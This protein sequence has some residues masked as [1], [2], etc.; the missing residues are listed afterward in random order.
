[1]LAAKSVMTRRQWTSLLEALVRIA[2]VGHVAWV[3]EVHRQVWE[4]V[5]RAL[6]GE[7]LP[8]DLRATIYPSNS[9]T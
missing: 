9:A 7:D 2:A 8:G 1:M 5:R 3:C 4:C 6:A